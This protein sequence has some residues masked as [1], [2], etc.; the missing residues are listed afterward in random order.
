MTLL[1]ALLSAEARHLLVEVPTF[2][3]SSATTRM[4]AA[5]TAAERHD[6]GEPPPGRRAHHGR[7]GR[8]LVLK[9]G[10]DSVPQLIG[11]GRR[12]IA[13]GIAEQGRD[14]AVGGQLRPASRAGEE[15]VLDLLTL[16]GVE[17]VEGVRPEQLLDLVVGHVCSPFRPSPPVASWP[18]MR[19]SPLRILLLTV[20]SGSPRS[21]ATSR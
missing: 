13:G 19:F 3:A 7:K 2:A 4:S 11:R 21:V 8:R 9:G 16:V 12:R 10:G 20:P 5:A 18:C 6:D 15:V 14:L 1:D 17:G